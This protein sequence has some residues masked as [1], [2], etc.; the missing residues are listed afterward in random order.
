MTIRIC[1]RLCGGNNKQRILKLDDSCISNPKSQIGLV[2]ALERDVL[3]WRTMGVNSAK[4]DEIHRRLINFGARTTRIAKMLPRTDEGRYIAQQ[5]MRSGLAAAANYAEARAAESP[6]RFHSQASDRPQ[7]TQ[8]DQVMARTNCGQRSLF[9]R[10]NERSYRG[11]PRTRL[12]HR[13]LD[14]NSAWFRQSNL[15]FRI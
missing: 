5:L 15:R 11:K 3:F 8:R 2:V 13:G 14:K 7:R 4:A 12:D 6:S 10:Q 1:L 9:P